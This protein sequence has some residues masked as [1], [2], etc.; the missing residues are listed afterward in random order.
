MKMRKSTPK[1]KPSL[2]TELPPQVMLE[3]WGRYPKTQSYVF[4][5]HAAQAALAVLRNRQGKSVLA[6][7]AGRSYGDPALNENNIVLD[8]TQA[9]RFFAFNPKT[10]VLHAE[11]GVTLEQIITTFVPRGW[12]LPATPGTKYPTLGG[13]VAADVHGKS[14]LSIGHFIQKLYMVLADGSQVSCSPKE[15]PDL[16][17]ATIGG[18]GLTGLIQSVEIK[19]MPIESSTLHYEG[20]KAKNLEHIFKIFEEVADSPLTVAWID[21]V[22]KGKQLGRSIMMSGSFAKQAEL[23]TSARRRD[24]LRLNQSRKVSVPIEL[25]SWS[26][27]PL[28]VSAFNALYYGKHPKR[29][30]S[31][32]DIDTFFYPL[33]SVLKWNR[34]YG[35]P[36]MAQYQFLI[37]PK[38]GFDG[39]QKVLEAIAKTGQASFL[40]VLKK[41]GESPQKAPLS[42]PMP[43][44]FIALDFPIGNGSILKEM[45]KWDEL[46][47]KY[48]GRLYLAKDS[49]MRQSTFE[50]MYPR[51]NEWKA[52]K[53]KYDPENVFTSDQA[54]RLGLEPGS[55]P[56][57]R[58]KKTIKKAVA[59]KRR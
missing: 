1:A 25:P 30:S 42:F 10:G 52:I 44:Y 16:F 56:T 57:T 23:K 29:V 33:D 6:R 4:H 9:D 22:A 28:T 21:C 58:K 15:K 20:I 24:P 53:K 19:L 41:F 7:G 11:A 37:P 5:L 39:I 3:G 13:S 50:A 48:E 18:M 31:L 14:K 59:K 47:L 46:V 49:R 12:F 36:G 27:N 40:S 2:P 8:Y 43:G 35:K 17:W 26:L 54:R 38:H 34:I 51:L 45:D 55:R 32:V